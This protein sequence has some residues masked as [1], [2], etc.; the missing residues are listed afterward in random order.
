MYYSVNLRTICLGVDSK[1][2]LTRLGHGTHF[3][4]TKRSQSN[5]KD[6]TMRFQAIRFQ[7]AMVIALFAIF[8]AAKSVFGDV[9]FY[10]DQTSWNNIVEGVEGLDFTAANVA[11]ANEVATPPGN[12]A[13]VGGVLTFDAA[14]TG[15]SSSFELS[16]LEPNAG[17]TFNDN[18]GSGPEW[19]NAL[20]I[21]DIDNFENDDWQIVFNSGSVFNF[22]WFLQDNGTSLGESFS[23][24]DLND[25]L[26]GT[27]SMIPET[28]GIDFVGVVSSVP[29]GR[30]A[31]DEDPGDDDI[32]IGG[33]RLSV[34][35]AIPEPSGLLLYGVL[36]AGI[37]AVRNRRR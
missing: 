4:L 2:S 25:N 24:Y 31:F 5:S 27:F 13:S 18:E 8:P 11:L 35:A 34:I 32:A 12:N 22:G 1:L 6:S 30:V 15:L 9:V 17:F 36:V 23:V 29:I 21:G 3:E 20:S 33:I 10:T 28:D 16:T 19:D 14:N 37:A 26:L 7:F